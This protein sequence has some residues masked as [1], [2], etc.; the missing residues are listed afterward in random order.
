L[1]VVSGSSSDGSKESKGSVNEADDLSVEVS[2]AMEAI[3]AL[4]PLSSEGDDRGDEALDEDAD[5]TAI[6]TVDDVNDDQ[7]AGALS[8]TAD[9]APVGRNRRPAIDPALWADV[10]WEDLV[11]RLLLLALSR[12]SRMTWRGQRDAVPPGAAEAQDFVNDAITK[13]L[14]GVRVWSRDKCSLFQHLA[15]VVVSDIS[16]AAAAS[17]NKLTLAADDRDE[18][19]DGWPPDKADDAPDQ[20]QRALWRSEQRRLLGHLDEV[21][22]KLAQM[23]EL[24]LIEDVDGS[25]ELAARLDCSTGDVANLRKRLKRALRVYML[26]VGEPSFEP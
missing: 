9:V 22:P 3:E 25:A 13:T 23:A 11:P 10:D 8:E 17:E 20:E 19:P 4:M 1:K 21:D 26:A 7:N 2:T 15:S 24:I 16:H 6:D 14:S 18:R 12:L 5:E